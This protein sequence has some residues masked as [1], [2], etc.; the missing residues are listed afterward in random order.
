VCPLSKIV[1]K[2]TFY[3]PDYHTIRIFPLSTLITLHHPFEGAACIADKRFALV[4]VVNLSARKK[5][6]KEEQTNKQ[7]NKQTVHT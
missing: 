4:S 2:H 1:Q 7:T 5:E 3:P 6:R